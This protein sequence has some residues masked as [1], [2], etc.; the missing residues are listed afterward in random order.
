MKNFNKKQQGYTLAEL[1]FVIWGVVILCLIGA[2][3]YAAV[4]FISKFW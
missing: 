1:L 3:I 2:G 4:H